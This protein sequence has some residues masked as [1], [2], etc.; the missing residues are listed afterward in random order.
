MNIR[1]LIDGYNLLFTSGMDGRSR[2]PGWLQRARERLVKFLVTHLPT[3]DIPTTTIVFDA[4]SRPLAAGSWETGIVAEP[5]SDLANRQQAGI[6]VV[7]AVDYDEA[8]DLLESLIRQHSTPKSLSVV[9]DDNRVR[10]CAV[11]RRAI[12]L[13]IETFLRQLESPATSESSAPTPRE[14]DHNL[15][16]EEV[17]RWLREFGE[18]G[19]S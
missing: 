19:E 9:S 4:A 17:T 2:A 15:S 7:F 16:P 10:K 14:R 18:S 8:D 5:R 6:Q 1:L 13:D 12:S 11:A 3:E